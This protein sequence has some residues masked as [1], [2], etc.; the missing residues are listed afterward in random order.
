M[1]YERPDIMPA[2]QPRAP[3]RRARGRAKRVPP[4]ETPRARF[5]RLVDDRLSRAVALIRRIGLL[6]AR[7]YEWEDQD[8]VVIQYREVDN[9]L[10]QFTRISSRTREPV[11]IRVERLREVAGDKPAS[12]RRP[13]DELQP[14]GRKKQN[15]PNGT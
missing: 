2:R 1:Q 11:T 15:E 14:T 9:A 5:L 12:G 3:T 6:S 4:D 8:I 13:G 10:R 7:Q